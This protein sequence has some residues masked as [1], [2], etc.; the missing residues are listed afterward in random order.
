[1]GSKSSQNKDTTFYASETGEVT[2]DLESVSGEG[3]V[4]V[5]EK[6]EESVK[7][8]KKPLTTPSSLTDSTSSVNS[9]VSD[10]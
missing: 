2:E 4:K 3:V 6:I 8:V 9:P 10:A 7:K 5:E 1:M